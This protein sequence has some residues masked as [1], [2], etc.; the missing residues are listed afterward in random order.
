MAGEHVDE[1]LLGG[2]AEKSRGVGS[3]DVGVELVGVELGEDEPEG[4]F[5]FGF[6]GGG[7]KDGEGP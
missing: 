4:C 2:S 3:G 1:A 7:R 6:W 5:V